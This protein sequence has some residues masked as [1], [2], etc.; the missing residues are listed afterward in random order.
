MGARTRRF[1]DLA[2]GSSKAK[3]AATAV[4]CAGMLLAGCGGS[5][6]SATETGAP[7]I[8]GDVAEEGDSGTTVTAP[9]VPQVTTLVAGDGKVTVTVAQGSSGGTPTSFQM[10]AVGTRS[11]C[12]VIWA[13]RTCDVMGLTNATPYT[14]TA[15]AT[16]EGGTSGISEPSKP[17]TPVAAVTTPK[18]RFLAGD[19]GDSVKEQTA[20]G[21]TALEANTFTRPGYTFD[22]WMDISSGDKLANEAVYSFKKDAALQAQWICKPYEISIVSALRLSD[23]AVKVTFTTDSE[24]PM[25]T[26]DAWAVGGEQYTSIGKGEP[27]PWDFGWST[28]PIIIKGLEPDRRYKFMVKVA[29]TAECTALSKESNYA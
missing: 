14:F 25:M 5:G 8:R 22:G 19:G 21:E 2:S 1:T 28:Y 3:A 24:L 16:N 15:T 23:S 7:V 9:G 17:V 4:V 27:G 29:N 18:V 12:T 10:T 6:G 26:L 20:S 11:T 13:T